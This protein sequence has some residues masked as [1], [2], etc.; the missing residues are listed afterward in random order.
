MIE[1][2]L[3]QVNK[4][5][6][7]IGKEWNLPKKDFEA[8]SIKFALSFPDLYEVGM[9]NLGVR[10]IYGILNNIP[11]V[12]CE[13]VFSCNDDLEAIIRQKDLEIFSLESRRMLKEFDIIGFSLGSELC[14]TN[15]LSILDLG[16]IPLIAQER[17]NSF[18]LVI[19]GG[20]CVLNPEPIHEFF[21]LF[22][23]GEAEDLIVELIDAYRQSQEEYKSSR[24]SKQDLLLRLSKIEGVYV[25]S[26]YEGCKPKI[27][28]AALSIKKRFVKDLNV[29]YFPENWLV[30]YIQIIHDRITLEIMRGC[31]N[32]CRFCQ[33][34]SC[35][36][37]LRFRQ[38]E[39]ILRLAGCIYKETGYE[40]ISLTGLSVSD[41]PNMEELSSQ[42]FELF[43]RKGISVS[44]PSIKAKLAV[45]GISSLIATVKKTGLTFAPEAGTK[46]LRDILGKDFNEDD[47]F[48]VLEEAY[49]AGYRHV[50]LYFMIGLPQETKEDLDGIADLCLRVSELGRKIKRAPARVN[51]SINTLIPKPHTA[52]Q[53]FGM[54]GLDSIKEK[55]DY[56]KSK[57][58][59]RNFNLSFH[60]QKMSLLEGVLSRGDRRLSRVIAL[61]Y[62]KGARFDAWGNHFSWEK[63]LDAF[64]EAGIDPDSYLRQRPRDEVLPWDTLEPGISKEAL[65]KEFN[66]IMG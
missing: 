18:P 63:W 10:I 55:Q 34:R 59:N 20:P 9:S 15:I 5:G 48:K 19:G 26:F 43:K 13:R 52:F 62:K 8:A 38:Q 6:R 56:L 50:K 21:D 35:Y 11:D 39:N 25:P 58:K 65:V 57:M 60:D 45:G 29:S 3:L 27:Q 22:V 46:R 49:L 51:I 42:M 37:P 54:E 53:W 33:A 14:Y 36:F 28:G 66:E 64:N 17:D 7:Y 16:N 24:I 1:D 32:R 41:Y 44:L 31:P 23:I 61:A 47:F 30:P 40:E 4:P 12:A 2:I